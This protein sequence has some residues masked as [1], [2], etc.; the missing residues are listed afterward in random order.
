MLVNGKEKKD[1]FA[2]GVDVQVKAIQIVQV[3][4]IFVYLANKVVTVPKLV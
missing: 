4:P 1:E 3:F 2:V